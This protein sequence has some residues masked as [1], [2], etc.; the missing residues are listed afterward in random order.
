MDAKTPQEKTMVKYLRASGMWYY[1]LALQF[2]NKATAKMH[3]ATPYEQLHSFKHVCWEKY[4]QPLIAST[5][6]D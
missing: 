3:D 5:A 6:V 2:G 4:Q 1:C